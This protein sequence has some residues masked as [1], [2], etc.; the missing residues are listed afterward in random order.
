MDMPGDWTST[1]R[2]MWLWPVAILVSFPVGGYIAAL[3]PSEAGHRHGVGLARV[4]L[5][6]RGT[7]ELRC[8]RH[9]LRPLEPRIRVQRCSRRS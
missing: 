8:P 2:R 5:R 4:G 1:A 6:R 9:C 7:D 3:V